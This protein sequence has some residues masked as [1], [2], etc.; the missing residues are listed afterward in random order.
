MKKIILAKEELE[1]LKNFLAEPRGLSN[2]NW[3]VAR[4]ALLAT[5]F[6][7]AADKAVKAVDETAYP[8]IAQEE[9]PPV[10]DGL[11]RLEIRFESVIN[12]TTVDD[13]CEASAVEAYATKKAAVKA[14][15]L[16]EAFEKAL[17]NAGLD[18]QRT[19]DPLDGVGSYF[20][21]GTTDDDGN[22][23]YGH[24]TAWTDEEPVLVFYIDCLGGSAEEGSW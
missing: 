10:V 1:A 18:V 6:M 9:E 4:D 21:S 23:V 13:G 7:R 15:K 2:P 12:G 3:E 8:W 24:W 14:S 16:S 19:G 17:G 5:S 20:V 11:L 22:V